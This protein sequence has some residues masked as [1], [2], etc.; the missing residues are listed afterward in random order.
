[1]KVSVCFKVK[2]QNT[3]LVEAINRRAGEFFRGVPGVEKVF[4]KKITS[5]EVGE[6]AG[7]LKDKYGYS[8]KKIVDLVQKAKSR[9]VAS[10]RLTAP[11]EGA[12]KKMVLPMAGAAYITDFVNKR[13]ASGRVEDEAAKNRLD[14]IEQLAGIQKEGEFVVSSQRDLMVKAA[15][16]IEDLTSSNKTLQSER[17]GYLE[18]IASL[19]EELVKA[20]QVVGLQKEAIALAADGTID[21][22]AADSW[23]ESN[24]TK[25]SS[26]EKQAGHIPG[27]AFLGHLDESS[28]SQDK[29]AGGS[30][31]PTGMTAHQ[32]FSTFFTS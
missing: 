11:F 18:K 3:V 4:R 29:G 21:P 16:T 27:Y 12:V 25:T 22:S 19:E 32:A 26:G 10:Y 6:A 15:S 7:H 17:Q 1:V 14:T 2:W 5:G 8:P 31:S 9:D 23:I 30:Q 24:M 28:N 13:K 20:S